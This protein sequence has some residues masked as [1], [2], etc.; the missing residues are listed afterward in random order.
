MDGASCVTGAGV[1]IRA[2]LLLALLLAGCGRAYYRRA[3]DRDAYALISQRIV[4]PEFDVGRTRLEPDPQSRLADPNNPDRPPKPPDDP[5]A[6]LFMARPGDM[7]GGKHWGR[8]GSVD[9]IENDTWRDSL[10]LDDKGR[11][12]LDPDRAVELALLN[13]RDYQTNLEALYQAALDL[14]LNRFEFALHWFGGGSITAAHSGAG[15][16]AGG[17]SNTLT[18]AQNLGFTRSLAAGGQ[19]LVDFANSFVWEYTAA[20]G[21]LM[22]SSL[23][24]NLVQPLLRGAGREIRL[25]TLTQSERD[26]LYAVRNFAHFRKA[27]WADVTTR[28]GYLDLLLSV[29][30]IRNQKA[31]LVSQEQNYRLHLELFDGG[32][33]SRVRVDQAFRTFLSARLGVKQAEASYQSGL[34]RFKLQLGLPPTLPVELD[35]SQLNQFQVV[36]P[37]LEKLRED[38]SNFQLARFKELNDVPTAEKL[39]QSYRELEGLVK[40]SPPMHALVA[41]ELTE[42]MKQFGK[43]LSPGEDP[44][45]RQRTRQDYDRFQKT[46]AEVDQELK[47]L[48]GKITAN[49]G[50]IDGSPRKTSWE[51]LLEHTSDYLRNLDDLIAI[52]TVVRISGIELPVLDE[53][54]DEAIAFAKANRLDLMNQ[55]GQVTDAWRKVTVAANALRGD[56]NIV[57]NA[58]LANDPF[59]GRPLGFSARQS[60]FSLGLQFDG[61]LNRFKE[62]NDYRSSQIAYQKARRDYMALSDSIERAVRNDLRQLDV[63]RLSFEISRQSVISASRQVESVRGAILAARDP[64]PTATI[65]ILNALSDLLSARNA[66]AQSYTSYEQL[67][68]QFLLDLERLQLDSRG[69]PVHEQRDPTPADDPEPLPPPRTQ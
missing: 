54:E 7:K 52:E 41:R 46:L 35:D 32:K 24:V 30:N 58:N 9:E 14:S 50:Q 2:G 36:A 6:A 45:Q 37:E 62:R 42:G 8:D 11:L 61:P 1:R 16:A 43:P 59:A 44:D 3:A 10:G 12:K 19:L 20:G 28:A 69:F 66:L 31:N 57:A 64:S 51:K 53:K 49:A 15:G 23:V 38:S 39:K 25:E 18:F 29:Q 27:F 60:S 22:P 17:E 33:V 48:P 26:L 40:R 47:A 65:D 68:I 13:S 56:L 67:R 21:R 5:A 4:S 63:E 34:D 55:K